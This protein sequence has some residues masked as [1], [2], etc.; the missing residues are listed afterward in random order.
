[1]QNIARSFTANAPDARFHAARYRSDSIRLNHYLRYY[2]YCWNA[3]PGV[4]AA[5]NFRS[6]DRVPTDENVIENSEP[7]RFEP[8]VEGRVCVSRR[9]VLEIDRIGSIGRSSPR[10][11]AGRTKDA[12]K[13]RFRIERG[14]RIAANFPKIDSAWF[15]IRSHRFLLV[16]PKQKFMILYLLTG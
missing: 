5:F 3:R 8:V 10:V 2:D 16:L 7:G 6:I 9:F 1:M 15:P 11:A 14:E 4:R 12:A 13:R